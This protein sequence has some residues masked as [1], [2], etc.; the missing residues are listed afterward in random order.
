MKTTFTRTSVLAAAALSSL[1][2]FGSLAQAQPQQ[3][4]DDRPSPSQQRQPQARPDYS[5]GGNNARGPQHQSQRPQQPGPQARNDFDGPDFSVG[6]PLPRD[7]RGKQ[8]RVDRWQ[9]HKLPAPKRGQHWVQHGADY[10]LISAAG[11]ILQVF[12]P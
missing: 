7:Y 10:A 8:Y 11:V 1:L 12:R 2:A 5:T 9:A 4:P 3:R 6:R